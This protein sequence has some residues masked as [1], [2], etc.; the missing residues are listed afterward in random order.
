MLKGFWAVT[1]M[2]FKTYWRDKMSVFWG[3]VFPLLL[4]GLIGSTFGRA[5]QFSATVSVAV[6]ETSAAPVEAPAAAAPLPMAPG[7]SATPGL[8]PVIPPAA[9]REALVGALKQVKGLTVIEEPLEKGLAAL[10]K[11]DRTLVVEIP[12]ALPGSV[13][14]H[15]DEGQA[16]TAQVGIAVV[17]QVAAEYDKRLTGRPELLT[18]APQA[19]NAEQFKLFDFLLPGILAMTFMQ[20]GLMGVTWVIA[21]YREKLVL[22]RVLTTPFHPFA[23]LSGLVT[24]F[25]VI[26]LLQGVIIFLV[27]TYVFRAKTIG[28]LLDLA[29][30]SIIG[31]VTFLAIGFAISTVSRTAES[32]NALGSLVNFPML[33]L[34]GTFWPRDLIPEALRPVVGALPLTPLVDAMRGVATR[35]DSLLVYTPGILYLLAWTAVAFAVAAWRFRW[36]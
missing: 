35:A 33:F 24:R 32:A 30:L 17:R 22:K 12:A 15:Y 16:Q 23:F 29:I 21:N 8:P 5:D 11:G 6:E 28:S 36:E 19:V 10:R 20:T 7:P 25:T 27:A 1:A 3:I 34:S 4:M 14:V 9:L 13:P 18:V 2:S 26:N 31:S